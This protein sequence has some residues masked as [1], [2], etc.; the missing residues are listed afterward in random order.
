MLHLVFTTNEKLEGLINHMEAGNGL[1]LM[2]TI[3]VI[4]LV[5]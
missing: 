5:Q 2:L 4:K 1:E 3:I